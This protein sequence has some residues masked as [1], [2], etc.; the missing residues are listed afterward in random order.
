MSVGLPLGLGEDAGRAAR[1]MLRSNLGTLSDLVDALDAVDGGASVGF[2]ADRVSAERLVPM[3]GAKQL[4][5]LQAGPTACDLLLAAAGSAGGGGR[6]SVTL[7]AVDCPTVV[8]HEVIDVS[9]NVDAALLVAWFDRRRA[10]YRNPL[11]GRRCKSRER[12]RLPA[13][14]VPDR[15]RCRSVSW[16]RFF[17]QGADGCGDGRR[18]WSG[19]RGGGMAP[20]V[21][22]CRAPSRRRQRTLP[23][24]RRR[25]GGGR[26]RLIVRCVTVPPGPRRL[27]RRP[28]A[29]TISCCRVTGL[30]GIIAKKRAQPGGRTISCRGGR[31]VAGKPCPRHVAGKGHDSAGPPP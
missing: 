12:A 11:P 15:R 28:G 14:P 26:Q 22:L 23:S 19:N 25:G 7:A 4:S 8:L 3:H 9:R 21:R 29:G 6:G 5:A 2:D 17:D 16:K 30:N 1:L 24:G 13:S 18:R 10:L 20:S 31:P 27:R